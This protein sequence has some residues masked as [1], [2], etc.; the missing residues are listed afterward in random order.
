MNTPFPP[1]SA[2][3]VAA[4]PGGIGRLGAE[5][6]GL[7]W[8]LPLVQPAIPSSARHVTVV[9]SRIGI[10]DIPP[11]SVITVSLPPT[12]FAYAFDR[13]HLRFHF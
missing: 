1:V 2:E 9:A 8:P 6:V 13:P 12:A 11:R 7:P 4:G 10:R 3:S 5:E